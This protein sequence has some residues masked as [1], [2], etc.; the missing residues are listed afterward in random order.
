MA[1]A[2]PLFHSPTIPNS[3]QSWTLSLIMDTLPSPI[4]LTCSCQ[5]CVFSR[6]L[7]LKLFLFVQKDLFL[8]S[9]ILQIVWENL[10]PL[11]TT[12]SSYLFVIHN[13]RRSGCIIWCIRISSFVRTSHLCRYFSGAFYSGSNRFLSWFNLTRI[14]IRSDKFHRNSTV[15]V[16]ILI[17]R[18]H[19]C[20]VLLQLI[21]SP[22]WNFLH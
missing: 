22:N 16:N 5:T 10:L 12:Y 2:I 18:I 4:L 1:L 7:M 14:Q 9:V 19:V 21:V 17:P 6:Y 13:N 3:L 8:N 20:S 11:I 15:Q